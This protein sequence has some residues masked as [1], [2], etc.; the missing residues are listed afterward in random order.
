MIRMVV[1]SFLVSFLS[2]LAGGLNE[3]RHNLGS[4]D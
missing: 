3:F 4:S 2:Q 1:L